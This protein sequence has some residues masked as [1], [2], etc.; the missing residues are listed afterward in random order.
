MN[1]LK[2]FDNAFFRFITG[3]P[4]PTVW[5][6][7]HTMTEQ[8]HDLVLLPGRSL[9]LI[10]GR[11]EGVRTRQ[12][13]VRFMTARLLRV[14][15]TEGVEVAGEA[16]TEGEFYPEDGTRITLTNTIQET[17]VVNASVETV[18]FPPA[19]KPWKPSAPLIVHTPTGP[20][21]F[22]AVYMPGKNG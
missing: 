17:L 8:Y 16:I 14:V 12:G 21:P 22:S 18:G 1:F 13:F 9:D 6:T 15:V 7:H 3:R 5:N 19:A 20:R 4:K 2:K 10:P 11:Q